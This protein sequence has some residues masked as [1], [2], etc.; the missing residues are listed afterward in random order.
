MIRPAVI[1]LWLT[2]LLAGCASFSPDGGMGEVAQGVGRE[3]GPG[4]GRNVVKIASF[5]QAQQAKE[6]VAHLLAMPLS[7]DAAV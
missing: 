6:Q 4:I 1:V 5:E 7:A 2:G 3:T